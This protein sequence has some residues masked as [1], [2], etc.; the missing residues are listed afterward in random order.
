MNFMIDITDTFVV[1]E[2]T[3]N[4]NPMCHAR[5]GGGED[6]KVESKSTISGEQRDAIN[7]VLEWAQGAFGGRA[8][9]EAFPGQLTADT[10]DLFNQAYEQFASQPYEGQI[11]QATS[12]LIEGRPAYE[13]DPVSTINRW[14]DT[15]AEPV[16]QAWRET[17]APVIKESLNLPG[18]LYGRGTSDYLSQR[19]SD[20]FSAN[21]AP[22]LYNSL[23]T[24][25]ALGAQSLE[26]AFAR[27]GAATALPYQQTAERF[28]V[29][30]AIQ[31][32]EQSSL[33]RIYQEYIRNDP[34]RYGQLIQGIGTAPTIENVAFQGQ[35]DPWAGIAASAAGGYFGGPAFA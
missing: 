23:Q 12:D 10:P 19:G 13:F 9:G 27:R 28:G 11:N 17:V 14:R 33:D 18:T 6:G 32:Q 35:Q 22:T 24:G 7:V 3:M 29:S 25:E 4:R 15:F 31:G 21:V 5:Y 34:F 2:I 16:M 26:N 1:N 20:F 8:A 30:S